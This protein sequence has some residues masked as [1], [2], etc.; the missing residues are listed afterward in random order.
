MWVQLLNLGFITSTQPCNC[1]FLD[2]NEYFHSLFSLHLWLNASRLKHCAPYR[3]ANWSLETN[4]S[5]DYAARTY[6]A[7]DLRIISFSRGRRL[8]WGVSMHDFILL[9]QP[10]ARKGLRQQHCAPYWCLTY[11]VNS[12]FIN[13]EFRSL[14]FVYSAPTCMP[15]LNIKLLS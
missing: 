1:I 11:N 3:A 15:I 2:K 5:S 8:G 14:G 12:V 13:I 7:V 4:H 10:P 6:R 9:T